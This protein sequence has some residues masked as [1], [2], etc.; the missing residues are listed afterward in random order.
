MQLRHVGVLVGT[1]LTVGACSTAGGPAVETTHTIVR[2]ERNAPVASPAPVVSPSPTAAP[3][4]PTTAAGPGA[5]TTVAPGP[6]SSSGRLFVETFDGTPTSPQPWA[7]SRWDVQVHSRDME[8]WDE[9]EPMQAH[10]GTDC[11][12]PPATHPVSSYDDAVFLCR[13]HMMTSINAHGYGVVYLTPD[14][15]VDFSESEATIS[16]DMSTLRTSG[17]DWVDLWIT[18]Y[19]DNL[20]L[21]FEAGSVDLQGPPRRALHIVMD[22]GG[23]SFQAELYRDFEPIDIEPAES[24]DYDEVLT[25]DAARRDTFELRL[26]KDHVAFGMPKYGLRWV[27]SSMP[28]LDWS[29]GVVQFGHHSYT[30]TKDCDEPCGPNTWHWDNVKIEPARPFTLLRADRRTINDETVEREVSFPQ[31]APE[32]SMLRLGGIGDGLEVSFDSGSTWVR[33]QEQAQVGEAD[34]HFRSFWTPVPAGTTTAQFRGENWWAGRWEVRGISIFSLS[35]VAAAGAAS[36]RV[37]DRSAPSLEGDS[38]C[39]LR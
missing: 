37:L 34:E 5:A 17:R 3:S 30:P 12:G 18:P 8:T 39:V 25:P 26:T 29:T 14:H 1:I 4:S 11:A 36:P 28:E 16:W 23:N 24:A 2:P 6:T 15:L 13:D 31:A 20:A 27:D 35:P 32:G 33:L 38:V 7:P 9:L 22:G 21:P 10:H 19:E